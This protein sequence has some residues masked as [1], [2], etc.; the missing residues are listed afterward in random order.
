MIFVTL[1]ACIVTVRFSALI[2]KNKIKLL[3][4]M[5]CKFVLELQESEGS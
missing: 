1:F 3:Y 4:L 2:L 5:S